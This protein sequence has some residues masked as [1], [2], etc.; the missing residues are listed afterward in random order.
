MTEQCRIAG[1]THPERYNPH[2]WTDEYAHLSRPGQRDIQ[3]ARLYDYRTNVVSY[4]VWQTWLPEHEPPT[5]FVWRRNDPSCVGATAFRR[6]LPDAEVRLLDA[7]H[8]AMDEQNDAIA[9][10]I[11]KFIDIH[12]GCTTN[13]MGTMDSTV[14]VE[15]DAE[16]GGR[17]VADV[18]ERYRN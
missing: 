2:T 11:S 14:Q 16:T 18:V 1:A 17:G 12:P 10:F 15:I 6:D 7:G 3:G 5:L 9:T 13:A 8:F 4:P